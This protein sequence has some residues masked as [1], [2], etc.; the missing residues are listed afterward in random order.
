[1][2]I[3][4]GYASLPRPPRAPAVAVGNFDG[5]HL[6][7]QGV[8]RAAAQAAQDQDGE[9]VVLT[10]DPH[11]VKVLAPDRAPALICSLDERA[12]RLTA[13]GAAAVVVQT[14][15]HAFSQLSPDEFVGT[16]VQHLG[17]RAVVVGHDFSF[18][19]GRAGTFPVLAQLCEA[20]GVRAIQVPAVEVDGQIAS[21]SAVRRAVR[22][23]RPRDAARLLGRSFSLR[24]EIV[25]GKARG[26]LLGFP[27]ANLAP[28]AELWPA[29]G[30]YACFAF[31]HGTRYPAVTNVGTAPT[32]GDKS[33]AV[34]AH[35]LDASL[36]LYGQRLE[37]SFIERIRAEQRFS[38]LDALVA[39]IAKDSATARQILAAEDA[40]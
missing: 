5:V 29:A 6:G 19:R 30:V 20:R 3:V 23:G 34:E 7:H 12:E 13:A 37:L 22:E 24:G 11:P 25:H 15:D 8:L 36:D 21:S 27:T 18:G 10:F 38:G 39:Q 33:A 14:F 9:L 31:H 1:M 26:R 4:R 35:L 17:A 16:L 40:P 28:E 2:P 32:F